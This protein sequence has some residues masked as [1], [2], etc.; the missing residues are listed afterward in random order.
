MKDIDKGLTSQ[1]NVKDKFA[2][3]QIQISG[4]TKRRRLNEG[5]NTN[6]FDLSKYLK[7]EVVRA[8]ED[9]APTD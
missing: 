9:S 3:G 6:Q 5:T 4:E 7:F 2:D 8:A 1:G